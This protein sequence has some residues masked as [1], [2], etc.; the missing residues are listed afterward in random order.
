MTEP[1]VKSLGQCTSKLSYINNNVT[2]SIRQKLYKRVPHT[3][4]SKR[5]T[6]NALSYPCH[7]RVTRWG[8]PFI[9]RRV[10]F[11]S[12]PALSGPPRELSGCPPVGRWV[13]A[14]CRGVRSRAMPGADL[15]MLENY[16]TQFAQRINAP[17]LN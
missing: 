1:D 3:P 2:E 12:P 10:N 11:G 8:T 13:A 6:A 9:P 17:Q 5:G 14:P 15:R 16:R 4:P 7:V